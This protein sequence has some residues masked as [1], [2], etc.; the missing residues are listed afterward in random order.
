MAAA[1]RQAVPRTLRTRCLVVG[2]GPAGMLLGLQLARGGVEVL[3]L[4]KHADFL[5]DFRGD[6]VHPSTLRLLD[7]LGLAEA[8]ARLPQ[9]RERALHV[10]FADRMLA[11]GDFDWLRPYPWLAF[12]PQWD[13]LNLLAARARACPT[14][15]LCMATEATALRFEHDDANGRVAGVLARDAGGPLRI[16][17]DLVVAADGRESVLRT[18]SALPL[19]EF[20]APMDVLW[21]RLPRDPHDADCTHG[22]AGRGQFMVMI[23][24]GDY[25]QVGLILPKDAARAVAASPPRLRARLLALAPEL[26]R[27]VAALAVDDVHRLQL[28]VSRLARRHRPGFA[29]I[30]D[31]AHAMSPIG[32]VGINLASRTPRP[33]ATCSG[34]RCV[35]VCRWT[36]RCW[37]GSSAGACSRR[38]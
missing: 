3:V 1:G 9:R 20:G 33:P 16:E 27:R 30:G 37:R 8:F 2:G 4:E 13:L 36:R 26:D 11:L 19:H 28:R 24:R 5:R 12:V 23:H 21:F 17:A 14:F 15:R 22:V 38:G 10:R 25:W 35:T 31:A 32:G 34:P 29:C 7:D 6:T 18:Q